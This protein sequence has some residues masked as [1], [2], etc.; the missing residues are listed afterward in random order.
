MSQKHP[1]LR[2]LP[3]TQRLASTNLQPLNTTVE[4]EE[5]QSNL[6]GTRR[7]TEGGP[8]RRYGVIAPI[9]KDMHLVAPFE[10]QTPITGTTFERLKR[11]WEKEEER[12]PI[13]KIKKSVPHPGRKSW[14]PG[15]TEAG[16]MS[17][18]YV[19]Y[20]AGPIG[21]HQDEKHHKRGQKEI[22][23]QQ[24]REERKVRSEAEKMHSGKQSVWRR[25]FR[26]KDK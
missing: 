11:E 7:P 20:L 18:N 24:E 17:G 3:T 1:S 14:V 23:K 8:S 6:S 21:D 5:R 26:R 10:G 15:P 2:R 13:L 12:N 16:Y 22:E 9:K 25:I 4:P 19:T